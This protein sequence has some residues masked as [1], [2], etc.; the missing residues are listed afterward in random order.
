MRNRDTPFAQRYPARR[1]VQCVTAED[2]CVRMRLEESQL[3]LQTVGHRD[4]VGVHPRDEFAAG[5]F[6]AS[7][8][9]RPETPI[10][11]A[12][13]ELYPGIGVGQATDDLVAPVGRPVI[14]D[15]ELEVRTVWSWMLRTACS[16]RGSPLYTPMRTVT[17][18][19][20]TGADPTWIESLKRYCCAVATT[21]TPAGPR[22]TSSPR[23]VALTVPSPETD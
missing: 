5:L 14:D 12:G 20:G 2:V 19:A 8:E 6:D 9:D 18:G 22:R 11:S 7:I 21:A 15:Q 13:D 23:S 3:L 4:I 10:R 17:G 1:N 16:R